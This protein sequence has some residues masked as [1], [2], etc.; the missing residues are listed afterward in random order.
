MLTLHAPTNAQTGML[1]HWVQLMGC[2][3]GVR[4]S[5]A[6]LWASG[7]I[8]KTLAVAPCHVRAGGIYRLCCSFIM[9]Q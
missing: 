7:K 4:M 5:R 3:A 8:Y 9:P 6:L 2:M 1:G